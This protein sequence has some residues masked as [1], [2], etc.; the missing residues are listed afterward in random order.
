MAA[1]FAAWAVP[2]FQSPEAQEAAAVWKRQGIDRFTESDFNAGNYLLNLPR[3]LGDQLPWLI[4][5]PAL[6]A[7]RLRGAAR[8]G[9]FWN[10][11][12]GDR[13]SLGAV[14]AVIAFCFFGVLL[15]P[16]T[17]P[18]YVLPL[19]A[20]I[21]LLL[22]AACHAHAPER[23]L[24]NWY[25][26]NICVGWLL[27]GV[28]L[29]APFLAS[30]STHAGRVSE[31]LRHLDFSRAA[32]AAIVA[33]VV[34]GGC[35]LIV[36]RRPLALTP[37]HL[38]VTS[39]AMFG[40]GAILFA[41]AAV[42][43]MNRGDELRPLAAEI[44][45]AIPSGQRLVIYEPGYFPAI[46]YLRT[47]YRYATGMEQVPPGAAF[48]LAREQSRKKFAERRPELEVVRTFPQK[49]RRDFLLLQQR[50]LIPNDPRP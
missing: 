35:A 22:A 37:S 44:D 36:A 18:R 15:I 48:V 19:G 50:D 6:I 34:I 2:F 20:P 45:A 1:I 26:V 11:L 9:G 33:T 13:T 21:A 28:A 23:T 49:D 7:G 31:A 5:A 30:A 14:A 38:A 39:G 29:A 40:A 42:P 41:I 4:F 47:P 43:W 17:L 3:A 25:R 27:I 32:V 8:A 12:R 46:F 16:G 24:R 10:S